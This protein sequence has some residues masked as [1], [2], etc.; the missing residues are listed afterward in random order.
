[1]SA[2][3]GTDGDDDEADEA[4]AAARVP[5]I[6]VDAPIRIE[7]YART[8]VG[9]VREHNEDAFVVGDLDEGQ[10]WIGDGTCSTAGDRGA[11]LAVCDGMGGTEGGEIAAALAATTLWNELRLSQGTQDPEVFARLMRRAVRAA[12]RRVFDEG[13]ARNMPGM[14]TTLS[15]AGVAG[16]K[17][18]VAQIGDS[19]A[20]VLRAGILTQVTRDQSLIS[21]LVAAGRY[22]SDEAAQ[23]ASS[24]ILQ[25]LG[26]GPDVDP[27]LS[28]IELRRGDR[29]LLCSDGLYGQLGESAIAVLLADE[30]GVAASAEALVAAARG[31]GGADN[32]T[33]VVAQ[34]DGNGL[35]PPASPEDLPKFREFDPREEGERAFTSTSYVARRLAARAGIGDDPGPPAVP[36]T[37]QHLVLAATRP[38]SP[39]RTP[40]DVRG[41]AQERLEQPER[42]PWWIWAIAAAVVAA[43]AW[44]IA[45]LAR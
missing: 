23:Q 26:V 36:A 37:G 18:I 6:V 25:A 20:Y 22:T 44:M 34:V 4:G 27:S 35:A 38:P 12:N 8:D 45:G 43:L 17:L 29:V 5:A 3:D 14:G 21:A 32:I 30:R 24:A 42:T 31:A 1:M 10:R 33:A 15:A 40:T 19:R 11:L 41:P 9:L 2:R 13:H 16:G 39:R 28:I 7:A